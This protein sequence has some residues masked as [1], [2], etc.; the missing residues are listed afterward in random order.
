MM[1][2]GVRDD[3][4]FQTNHRHIPELRRRKPEPTIYLN[5]H[6]AAEHGIAAADW[7]EVT[8]LGGTVTALAEIRDDMPAGLVRVPHG[9]WKPETE[10]GAAL[11]SGAMRYSDS[12]VTIDHP[13]YRDAEQGIPHLRGI[14]CRVRLRAPAASFADR[15][16]FA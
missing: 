12:L 7:I 10:Q 11:L 14:P 15:E 3:E 2:M 16:A 5:P 8:T 9:W 6:D 4:Y 1:F 13:D